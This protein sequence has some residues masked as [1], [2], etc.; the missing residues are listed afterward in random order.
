LLLV[1]LR[2][3]LKNIK[4]LPLSLQFDWLGLTSFS[5]EKSVCGLLY[6]VKVIVSGGELMEGEA[7]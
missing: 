7:V 1:D 2:N 3:G 5:A 6:E 4:I